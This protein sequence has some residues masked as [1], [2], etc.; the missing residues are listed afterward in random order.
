[1]ATL[2]MD[3]SY[4]LRG[5]LRG[6]RGTEWAMT[7][8]VAGESFVLLSTADLRRIEPGLGALGKTYQYKPVSAYATLAD[9]DATPFAYSGLNLKP[10]APVHARGER[11]A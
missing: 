8:H 4:T 3:G 5:L 6:R 2:E 9:T 10:L 1:E 11:D 7:E